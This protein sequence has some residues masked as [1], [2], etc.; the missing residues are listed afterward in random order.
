MKWPLLLVLALAAIRPAAAEPA[1]VVNSAA[2]VPREWAEQQHL[3]VKGNVLPADRLAELEAWLDANAPNWTVVLTENANGETFTDA[4][5]SK[6]T[7]MDA[8]EHALGKTLPAATGFG[9][10]KHP[11]TGERSGAFFVIFLKERKF[12]YNGAD[13]YDRRG[14]GEG[15]FIGNLDAP[16]IRAMRGGGRVADAVKDTV[17]FIDGELARRIAGEAE[18]RRREEERVRR[19]KV[20]TAATT[21][22]LRAR[23][24]EAQAA[25]QEIRRGYPAARGSLLTQQKDPWA[26]Q[27]DAAEASLAAGRNDEAVA[28][29]RAVGQQVEAHL[30]RL[31]DHARGPEQLE[32]QQKETDAL[33]LHEHSARAQSALLESRAALKDAVA[34]QANADA[35][36]ADKLAEASRLLRA[37]AVAD[38]ETRR[39]ADELARV[40]ARAEAMTFPAES[41]EAAAA[42]EQASAALEQARR[43]F[44]SGQP[45]DGALRK[46]SDLLT[47]TE[48]A[49]VAW[50]RRRI[51]RRRAWQTGGIVAGVLLVTAAIIGNRRRRRVRD[52]ALTLLEAWD[53]AFRE[54]TDGLF[55]L[56][57]RTRTSVGSS[58]TLEASG[59]T[60]ETAAIARQTIRDVDQLFVM[61]S[62]IDGVLERSRGL[63]LPRNPL[64]GAVNFV[65]GKRYEDAVQLLNEDHISF[66]PEDPLRPV[67]QAAPAAEASEWRGLLGK[68]ED[69]E[70]FSLTFDEL[71]AA[72][73]ERATRALGSLDRID[74]AW[75]NISALRQK[76][77]AELDEVEKAEQKIHDTSLTDR[78]FLLD[79]LFGALLP[80]A[81]DDQAEADRMSA[82]DPVQALEQPLARSG[83]KAADARAL[84]DAV[85]N[86]RADSLP[87]MR[88][89]AEKLQSSGR[90]TVW[91]DETLAALSEKAAVIAQAAV[92]EDQTAAI[93]GLTA[94]LDSLAARVRTAAELMKR[95]TES[96]MPAITKAES[97]VREARAEL[98]GELGIAAEKVLCEDDARNPSVKLSTAR[99]QHASS[100]AEIDRGDVAAAAEALNACDACCA[101]ALSLI[102]ET[103]AAFAAWPED[104]GR[105]AAESARLSGTLP[106]LTGQLRRMETAWAASALISAGGDTLSNNIRDAE[107]SLDQARR[108]TA[109]SER[110]RKAGLILTAAAGHRLAD[111]KNTAAAAQ[112]DEIGAH[113]ERLHFA[114]EAN[115]ALSA[116]LNA[117]RQRLAAA[118]DQPSAMRRSVDR[119]SEINVAMDRATD[120]A[121]AVGTTT[122][123]FQAAKDLELC[124]AMLQ[125]FEQ[126]LKADA[127]R[128]ADA[129]RSVQEAERQLQS[130]EQLAAK[131]Q[132]DQIPDSQAIVQI[133]ESIP[134][135]IRALQQCRE[136]ISE[137]HGDWPQL[138]SAADG[139]AA[140]SAR[141]CSVL[142]GELN[143]AEECTRG[144][145]RA[146]SAIRSLRGWSGSFGISAD[147]GAGQHEFNTARDALAR[148]AYAEAARLANRAFQ[149]AQSALDA[150]EAEERRQRRERE[151]REEEARRERQRRASF[152]T[153]FGHSSSSGGFSPSRSSAS[154]SSSGTS[155]S[156]FSSGS[157]TARSGW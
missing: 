111:E 43:D 4:A 147:T 34:A 53:K 38:T 86:L 65:A 157:G 136:R 69:T 5:G 31:A 41:K 135:L 155:R 97:A 24:T 89:T 20:E 126:Q 44:A 35:S 109:E 25:A 55:K 68:R 83:R 101:A 66:G 150:A 46:A 36:W 10:L 49:G 80:S 96:C 9:E 146:A 105:I 13:V 139:I 58:D 50:E 115:R 123:P 40:A 27:L 73:N 145:Q 26:R 72:F 140:E 77:D 129:L 142:S 74:H 106:Q 92:D 108:L 141:L 39:E 98:G 107:S 42:M 14:L 121:A 104:A 59:W 47:E 1:R 143:Q 75:L 116:E 81:R 144:L 99:A 22:A 131:S 93:A 71:I 16:A 70:P 45:A 63:V 6:F 7:G 119:M 3:Y 67:L 48:R 151:R 84:C 60:G 138:D 21:A 156:S 8:V 120:A 85:G 64:A 61:S 132:Q 95:A 90:R 133:T 19:A 128:H 113:E 29:V 18:A 17:S 88:A 52:K 62:A 57:D 23:L 56:M 37:A 117:W 51:V 28:A 12:G 91:M 112:L 100:L 54:K 94:E 32:A 87:G 82:K 122:D 153:G 79:P 127:E 124:R 33:R 102:A 125:E 110:Q 30:R 130:L 76:L 2:E 114:A 15:N 148:G 78:L 149:Q 134:G 154:S 118:A 11:Q 152:S 103:R 137:P